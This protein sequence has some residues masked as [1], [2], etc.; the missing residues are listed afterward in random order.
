MPTRRR[1][2]Q[3]GLLGLG[4]L[5]VGG[6]TLVERATRLREP[7]R[8]LRALTPAEFSVVAAIADRVCPAHGAFI[9]SA[10]ADVAERVDELL[11]NAEPGLTAEL[12]QLI[13]LF[14]NALTSFAFGLRPRPFTQ[15]SPADQDAVLAA[16]RD[17]RLNLRRTGFKALT[18]LVSAAYYSNPLTYAAVAYPGP[19]N[20]GPQGPTLAAAPATQLEDGP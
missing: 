2:L 1:V 4:V 9:S 5:A 6:V 12:R 20:I 3:T 19:P 15:M 16:W 7:R 11:A 17:S 18:G 14:E 13:R 10:D 8:P